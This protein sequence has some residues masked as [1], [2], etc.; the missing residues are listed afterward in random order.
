MA[1]NVDDFPTFEGDVIHRPTDN[2]RLEVGNGAL[3]YWG[4]GAD[5][6]TKAYVEAIYGYGTSSFAHRNT[7]AAVVYAKN[8]NDIVTAV[9]YAYKSGISLAIRS[10]GH[11]YGAFCSGTKKD[12]VIDL[13]DQS[14]EFNKSLV[15]NA[16]DKTWTVGAGVKLERL[17]VALKE[18]GAFVTHGEC[19]GVRCGGHIHTGGYSPFFSRSFGFFVDH[20]TE[21]TIVLAPSTKTNFQAQAKTVKKPVKNK[22]SDDDN[23][24]FAVMGGSPGHF[25]V[26]TNL[27]IKPRWDKDHKG[28][29]ALTISRPYTKAGFKTAIEILAEY[30]DDDN[31]PA[32]Y[33]INVFLISSRDYLQEQ[34][35]GRKNLDTCMRDN[36]PDIYGEKPEGVKP[37]FALVVN[38]ND[39]SG[40]G[41]DETDPEGYNAAE[42]FKKIKKRFNMG[43]STFAMTLNELGIR[44]NDNTAGGRRIEIFGL[45]GEKDMDISELDTILGFPARIEAS[46]Y[47]GTDRLFV[48]PEGG[49]NLGATNFVDGTVDTLDDAHNEVDCWPTPQWGITGG[50]HSRIRKDKAANPDI[51]LSHRNAALNCIYYV[52]YD[53]VK[54]GMDQNGPGM[55]ALENVERMEKVLVDAFGGDHRWLAFCGQDS[56]LETLWPYYFDSK[57]DYDRVKKVKNDYDPNNVFTAHTYGVSSG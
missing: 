47:Y 22:P 13:S 12:I 41:F 54:N 56:N 27:T 52:H 26:V 17:I 34:M 28:A 45:K 46:P 57:A 33:D 44:A 3:N 11:Q 2:F 7:P 37:L 5:P 6:A 18:K 32:D 36:R 4:D 55:K 40:V 16:S 1:S 30:C 42:I 21:F 51:A 9:E 14:A 24:W 35:E 38:W 8:Q 25:G 53:N 19:T 15:Y 10:G 43:A 31:L 39:V 29:R 48:P 20:I 49:P 50:K 23:L